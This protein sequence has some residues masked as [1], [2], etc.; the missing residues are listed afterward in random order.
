MQSF[1]RRFARSSRV[2]L[3][4]LDSYAAGRKCI[5]PDKTSTPKRYGVPAQPS[6]NPPLHG[7]RGRVVMDNH[8]FD[9]DE[10]L[11]RDISNGVRGFLASLRRDALSMTVGLV[12]GGI[13]M[14]AWLS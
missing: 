14:W 11:R 5:P 9:Y 3:T 7:V 13:W 4:P 8:T 12:I 10:Q 1:G 6:P 2:M